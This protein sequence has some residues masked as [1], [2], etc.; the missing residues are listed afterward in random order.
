MVNVCG[1]NLSRSLRAAAAS[2]KGPKLPVR[3]V[4]G[5]VRRGEERGA[6]WGEERGGVG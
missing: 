3:T 5:G 1:D 6:G 2:W 4:G